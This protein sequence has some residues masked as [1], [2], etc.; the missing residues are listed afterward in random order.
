M[1]ALVHN[2][3]SA[4]R[5]PEL[6]TTPDRHLLGLL[7]TP[8]S[9]QIVAPHFFAFGGALETAWWMRKIAAGAFE[10]DARAGQFEIQDR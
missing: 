7:G 2:L 5:S 9:E 8:V 1:R 6:A 3:G 4:A 10:I